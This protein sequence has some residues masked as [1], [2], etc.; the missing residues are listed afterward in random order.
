M[1][2]NAASFTPPMIKWLVPWIF[3]TQLHANEFPVVIG[4]T[5][6]NN[7]PG[8][9]ER[10]IS[11]LK[12]QGLDATLNVIPGE[13][14][15]NLLQHGRVALDIIR[16][17][18]I[19][20]H[21]PQLRQITPSVMN[22]HWSRIVSSSAKENC[23]K[24]GKDLSVIGIKGIRAFEGI[25]APKFI[26]ITWAPTKDSA[27]RMVSARRSDATFWM[28]NRLDNFYN[29]YGK[30][31]AVCTENEVNLSLHSYLHNSYEWALPKV[32][33]AYANLFETK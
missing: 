27:F 32:D 33:T 18:E 9:A 1:N 11:A 20:K 22:L 31:L 12:E 16:H 17:A 5:A 26:R 7:M 6:Y 14:A 13:R 30:T 19:V 24:P 3:I 23:A 21:Y 15:L 29:H 8:L 10:I 28:K 2:S 25:I 4:D